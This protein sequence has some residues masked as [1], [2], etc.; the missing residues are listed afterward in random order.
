MLIRKKRNR[1]KNEFEQDFYKLP[2]NAF[3]G[4]TMKTVRNRIR[5]ELFKKD[6]I[7]N[8]I[9]QQSNLT[10]NGTHKSCGNCDSYTFKQ[11]EVL[12]DKLIYLGF[13]ILELSKFRM[14][15]T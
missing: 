7:K 8:N 1:A 15:E 12:M 11:N 4:K 2:D 13:S 6:D 14:Y 5:L 9:Q 10:F 3:Y